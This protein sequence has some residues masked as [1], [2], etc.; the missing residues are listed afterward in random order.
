[1]QGAFVRRV[2][3][4]LYVVVTTYYRTNKTNRHI[5]HYLGKI[6]DGR[7]YTMEEYCRFDTRGRC[8][9]KKAEEEP[10]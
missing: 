9:K 8:P 5:Y 3:K 6:R 10:Q 4:L 2:G 1:M 7:F